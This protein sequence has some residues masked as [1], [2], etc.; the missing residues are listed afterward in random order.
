MGRI[1]SHVSQRTGDFHLWADK[2]AA[3]RRLAVVDTALAWSPTAPPPCNGP[4]GVQFPLVTLLIGPQ[5]AGLEL[6]TN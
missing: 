1:R 4:R 2:P 3:D 5:W 6:D